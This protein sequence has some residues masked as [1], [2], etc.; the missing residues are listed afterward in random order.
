MICRASAVPS[1]TALRAPATQR[2][3]RGS[4]G[5]RRAARPE[6]R[7]R[8]DRDEDQSRHGGRERG[9]PQRQIGSGETEC[10]HR[11]EHRDGEEVDRALDQK[12]GD[13]SAG[14]SL[15]VHPAAVQH[16]GAKSQSAGA[17]GRDQRPH[18][19]LR[20]AD[21]PAPAPGQAGAEDRPEHEDVGAEGERLE[22]GRDRRASRGWRSQGVLAL[23]RARAPGRRSRRGPRAPRSPAGRG[24]SEC[25]SETRP[26][27][28][29]TTGPR[30]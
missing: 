7:D 19:E 5:A 25:P 29:A 10:H 20:A 2:R 8:H 4:L 26:G 11:P 3:R 6:P 9:Q 12:E 18:R 22:A 28:P 24:G 23:P 30:P 16:P 15:P 1:I 17:A 27:A 21:L 14:D 13:R